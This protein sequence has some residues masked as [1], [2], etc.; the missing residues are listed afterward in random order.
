[1]ARIRT[2]VAVAG[3]RGR[4]QTC[5][6]SEAF[7]ING[8]QYRIG[9]LEETYL[10]RKP[11]LIKSIVDLIRKV[12]ELP[13]SGTWLYR[14]HHDSTLP[15]RCSLDRASC[16]KTR[17]SLDRSEH[18]KRLFEEFKRRAIPYLKSVPQ[19]DWW[20]AYARHHHGL[21]TR[22]LDWTQNPLVAAYF[23]VAEHQGQHDAQI[24]AYQ[25]NQPPVDVT[26][27]SPFNIRR[28][29]L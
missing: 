10:R 9:S 17:G 24:I 8:Q 11:E 15:L 20:L 13:S 19:N 28:I 3:T 16:R 7:F 12:D 1:M 18:E 29:E 23:A 26:S 5:R 2:T 25:H 14:G 6:S 27:T 4:I 21:P 22:L